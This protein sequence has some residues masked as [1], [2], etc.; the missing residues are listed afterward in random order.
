[1][2]K[3]L[4]LVSVGSLACASVMAAI[5]WNSGS[6]ENI[7]QGSTVTVS[8]NED[9]AATI[10]DG[11]DGTGWQANAATHEYTRDWVLI[12]LGTE[13]TFT[14][15]EI[16]WEASHCKE[17]SVYV[18]DAAIPY[19]PGETDGGVKYNA[20]S[21][22]WLA[23]NQPVVTRGND[24]ETG[25]TDNIA[26]DAAQTGQYI[27]I[28][29]DEYNN[30][31]S[32]YGMRIFDVKIANIEG[33]DEISGLKL[34]SEGN[35]VANGEA[36]TVTV[37]PVNKIG[38]AA[39][40]SAISG[41]TL[42]CD[43]S[44]VTIE[45]G[46]N[47]VYQVSSTADGTFTL[48]A[49]ATANGNSISGTIDLTFAY[50]WNGIENIATGKEIQGRVKA[51]AE[52]NN[53]PSNAVDGDLANYYQYNGEWGGG[54]GWL[55]VDLGD[56]YMV[57][58]IGAYYSTNA[59][60]KCVFG[61]ATDAAAI[62]AKIA[63]DGT[64]FRWTADLAENAGW[65]FTP[66][67]TRTADVVTTYAYDA[68][69]VARYIV[70]K[71]ADN[72]SGKPCVNE[73][74]VSGTKREAPKAD[75]IEISLEKGGLVIGETNTVTATVLDQYGAP[76]EAETPAI[77]VTGAEYADGTITA[78]AKGMVTVTATVGDLSDEVK[79]YVADE[80][81][82]CLAGCEITASEGAAA[83]KAPVTDGGKEINNWGLDY[84][85]ASNEPAGAHEHWMLVKLAKP[86]N[87]DLIAAL[88][89][90][91]CPADYDIYLGTTENDLTLYYF[92]KDKPGLQ[93]YSDRFSGKEMNAI[94]Y[95]KVVTTKNATEYGIKLHDLKVY[96][97]SDIESVPDKIEITAS[98]NDIVTEETV[99][100]SATVFDQFG[101]EMADQDVTYE[102]NDATIE[103]NTFKASATGEYTVTATC[104]NASSEIVINVVANADK[105]MTAEFVGNT[106]T[107]NG[108]VLANVN[109]LNENN[110]LINDLPA[111]LVVTFDKPQTFALL[112]IR[113]ETACPS[114]YTVTATYS[115]NT[116]ATIL[117]VSDRKFGPANPIDKIVNSNVA[118]QASDAIDSA[119]LK[120]VK[121]LTFTI[122]AKDHEYPV[123]LFG[124]DAYGTE[125]YIPTSIT[126]INID[127]DSLIDV[128]TIQGVKVRS[129]VKAAEALKDLPRGIYIAGGRKVM[130]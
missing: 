33:R 70:V 80:N 117:S 78:N 28:Y 32:Q 128:Y 51:D 95:I 8:S 48:T 4:S 130:I 107:L 83:D 101:A 89:E 124:I 119:D 122:T 45:G 13:K 113:W 123:R 75:K 19:T 79:F 90:G 116:T 66:E 77:T 46:E 85:L 103:G 57:N 2:K 49:A 106:V 22:E 58:A 68:P 109:I 63:A 71:D 26:F 102:C 82:Y 14:D 114:V 25:Y 55:L 64:D 59:N 54:D 1:M 18:S 42:S 86:Y 15:M 39:D 126:D 36:V 125:S 34:T 40:F 81:D 98:D 110:I 21:A 121:S 72:P 88:W 17:Y 127:S 23:A 100:L 99:T 111:T 129:N 61:Y 27:L 53:P 30:F 44:A 10:V 12:N 91:A 97:T 20:I 41:L 76:F 69:V 24:T 5:D 47:G 112:A 96:G 9:T 37:T 87:I 105:K 16:V 29:A 120:D 65:T 93:N 11:N 43:N 92:E 62:E 104:G 35:A 67:L 118:A 74:Y 52:D 108:D 3:F 115:N 94:Q 84:V 56:E 73:I 31:G 6:I 38:E 60:G 50:N 7:A